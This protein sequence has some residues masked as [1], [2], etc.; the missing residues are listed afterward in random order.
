[1]HF[2]SAGFPDFNFFRNFSPFRSCFKTVTNVPWHWEPGMHL[3]VG[4][5]DPLF[6]RNPF[7]ERYPVN[8]SARR[9]YNADSSKI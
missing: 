9:V 5:V 6:G 4:N 1:M 3:N 2:Q 7:S 8:A